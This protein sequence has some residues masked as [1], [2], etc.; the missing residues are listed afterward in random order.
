MKIDYTAA[1]AANLE[2]VFAML[3]DHNTHE[4]LA[5][6][7]AFVLGLRAC[8]VQCAHIERGKVHAL[9]V[10]AT[11]GQGFIKKGAENDII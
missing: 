11:D 10:F 1:D 3:N 4:G 6:R 8:G 2:Q 5:T 9:R 7:C